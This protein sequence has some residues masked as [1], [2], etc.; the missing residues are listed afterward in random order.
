MILAGGLASGLTARSASAA[1]A[2]SRAWNWDVSAG[3]DS[4]TH[5]YALAMLDTSETVSE[6][7]VRIG[8]EGRSA[9]GA[10]RRWR[11]RLEGSAGSDL[12]RERL[13]ADWRRVDGDGVTRVRAAARVAGHQY[14]KGTDLTQSSDQIE[15]RVDLQLVPGAGT[16]RELFLLGWGAVTSFSRASPLEQDVREAG[17]GAGLRSRGWDGPSWTVSLRRAQRAYPDSAAIDRHSWLAEADLHR[18]VGPAGNLSLRGLSERRLAADPAVRPDAWF[19]WLEGEARLPAPT[20]ELVLQTQYERWAHDQPTEVYR[21]SWRLAGLLGL[22]QGDVLKAQGMLG[23]ALE[24]YDAGEAPETYSQTGLRAGLES[25]ASAVSGSISVEYG[26]RR[27]G[28]QAAGDG[29]LAYSDFNYWRLWLVADWRLGT[30]LSLSGLGSWEPER[31][32]EAQDDVSLG[33]ASL[34]LVWRP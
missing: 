18:S 14:R 4:F 28:E 29:V 16:R 34:R 11:L 30:G 21:D 10:T 2:D 25:Y 9:P 32:V 5:T 33:F 3:Y 8:C 13:E 1:P 22:R 26:R 12:W 20:G 31:H 6:S 27:Y 24:R 15:G 19:H 17:L 7:V 23:L